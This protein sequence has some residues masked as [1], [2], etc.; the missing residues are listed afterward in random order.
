MSNPVFNRMR[1]NR[2]YA[3]FGPPQG[4]DALPQTAPDLEAMYRQPSA[5][6]V[7]SGRMS[8][9]DVIV[10]T[11][12]IFAALL[13]GAAAGW[14]VPGL[15]LPGLVVG[16]VLGLVN[17]FKRNPSP[18]LILG[19]GLFEGMFLGAI[20][21]FLNNA[22]PGIALQAVVGTLGVFAAVLV[23]F[24]SGKVRATPRL[25]K[26]F[27]VAMMGYLVFGLVNLGIVLFTGHSLRSGALGVVIGLLAIALASYSLVMDFEFIKA[28]V[29][30][31]APAKMAWYGGFGLVVTLVWLYVEILRLLSIFRSN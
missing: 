16:L 18:V 6:T 13:V 3:T 9:D 17:S 26:I 11:A 8:Y 12:T 15:L 4:R 14:A 7:Q 31:G 5:T 22:Y 23:L 24:R 28:G 19:Y 10:K 29:E 21:M 27:F 1:D 30:Q 2:G 20:S 25:N